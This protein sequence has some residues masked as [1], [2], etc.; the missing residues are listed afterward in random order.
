M[1]EYNGPY[2]YANIHDFK[3]NISKYIR[4]LEQGAYQA[5]YIKRHSKVV[6]AFIVRKP[7][8]KEGAVKNPMGTK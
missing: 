4:L 7:G 3:S 5:V 1:P 2:I 6:G 8:K